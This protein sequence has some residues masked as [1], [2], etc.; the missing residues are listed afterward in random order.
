[1][2][3]A[4]AFIVVLLAGGSRGGATPSRG[5]RETDSARCERRR[6]RRRRAPPPPP[7]RQLFTVTVRVVVAVRPSASVTFSVRVCGPSG[8]EVVGHEYVA[9]VSGRSLVPVD[10]IVLST[11]SS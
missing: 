9:V 1:M 2:P 8:T 7:G 11:F 5:G 4:V 10:T 3:F 6:R